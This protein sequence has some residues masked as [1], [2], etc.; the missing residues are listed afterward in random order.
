MSNSHV[1][2]RVKLKAEGLKKGMLDFCLPLPKLYCGE[3]PNHGLYIEMKVP[4]IQSSKISTDQKD[5]LKYLIDVGY[6]AQV[7]WSADEAIAIIKQYINPEETR[8]VDFQ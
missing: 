6:E 4:P 8:W 2:F 7:A 3:D 1:N 5:V